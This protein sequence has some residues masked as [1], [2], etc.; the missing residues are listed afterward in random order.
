MEYQDYY[1]ILGVPKT[2]TE[3]DIRSAYRKLARQYHPD[4]NKGNKEA[5]EKFK[6]VNEAYEVLSDPEKRKKYDELSSRWNEF[7]TWDH[8]QQATGGNAGAPWGQFSHYT[9]SAEDLNDL[10]GNS[11]PYSSFFE[12]FFGY[13]R[14]PRRGGDLMQR[15]TVSLEEAYHGTKLIIEAFGPDGKPRPLEVT[16]PPGVDT[17]TTIRL[18]GQGAPGIEGGPPGDRYL[19]I[20]VKPHPRFERR[21]DDLYT[22]VAV[23]LQTMLLGGEVEVPTLTGKVALK[24]PPETANGKVF[25]LRGKGMPRRGQPTQHGDL[26]VEVR[27][28][29]PRN[30]SERQ[31]ELVRQLTREQTE[32]KVG[33]KVMAR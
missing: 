4:L 30:L 26:Y 15:V 20:E 31:K 10:F 17:G 2:A 12:Q 21:G 22:D 7:E 28:E 27:V 8:A 32:A 5:E 9:T 16:I 25:R 6:K 13:P 18:A 29:L 33:E 3:K 11:Y 19:E 14:G 24:I 1:A 23:P